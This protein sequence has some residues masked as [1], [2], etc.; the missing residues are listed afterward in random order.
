MRAHVIRAVVFVGVLGWLSARDAFF[1]P[2]DLVVSGRADLPWKG[3]LRW[4]TGDGFNAFEA[5][6]VTSHPEPLA[7][8]PHRLEVVR[9]GTK[10][11]AAADAEVWV[12]GLDIEDEKVPARPV[13]LESATVSGTSVNAGGRVCLTSN[14]SSL[15]IEDTFTRATLHLERHPYSG[16]ARVLLDGVAVA[17]VDLYAPLD[18]ATFISLRLEHRFAPGPFTARWALPQAGLEGLRLEADEGSPWPD[19]TDARIISA[20]GEVPLRVPGRDAEGHLV[21]TGFDAKTRTFHPGLLAMHLFLALL[22]AWLA[23]VITTL[24]ARTGQA[25]WRATAR[26]LVLAD[27]RWVFWA[28]LG[29]SSLVFST[30]LLGFWPGLMTGDSLDSWLQ[31]KRMQFSNWNPFVYTLS[32][33]ALTR[34]WDSP[35][36]IAVLQLLGTAALGAWVF[37]FVHREG[38]SLRWVLPFYGLFTLSIPVGVYTLLVWRDVPFCL[39]TVFWACLLFVLSVRRAQ[40]RPVEWGWPTMV[41]LSAVLVYSS[42]VRHNGLVSLFLLPFLLL[43][44]RLLP[45]RRVAQFFALSCALYAAVVWGL[46]GVIGAHRNT[47][48]RIVSLSLQ[49]NT[50]ASVLGD[51][52]GAYSDDPEADRRILEKF[53]TREELQRVYNPLSVTALVY[54]SDNRLATL[55]PEEAEAIRRLYVQRMSENLHLFLA[56]RTMMFLATLGFRNWGYSNNLP[57]RIFPPGGESLYY[58][59]DA[60]KVRWLREAQDEV[61]RKSWKFQ[62]LFAGSFL[63]WNAFVPLLLIIAAFLLYKWLPMTALSCAFV[64]THA[65]ALFFT[66]ISN[67]F[68][69]V[70]FLQLFA[71]FLV[72]MAALEWLLARR[73][74]RD[75]SART[76]A[77]PQ[78]GP[79]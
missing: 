13:S 63:F 65:A 52:G 23:G 34:L 20:N 74:R 1:V 2:A 6:P 31:L 48:Y 21:F 69:Y 56:E 10:N 66:V 57:D 35:A 77:L 46:G 62:G 73:V 45:V 28:M 33:F 25:S 60:P 30:W 59:H 17:E 61:L 43:V 47:D 68:R 11:A 26:H 54:T 15:T 9:V 41:G 71:Y 7:A 37:S 29:A 67:D 24:P 18:K 42:T 76:E 51:R 40:G 27:R 12:R 75:S 58:L 36:I 72:P 55:K 16:T 79:A 14:G 22:L 39:L 32:V 19:F 64:L 3:T 78:A 38:L 5:K 53:I 44:S 4:S 8:G 50:W 49:L 70:Y